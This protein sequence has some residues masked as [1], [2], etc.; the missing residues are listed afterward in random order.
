[1]D[2]DDEYDSELDDFIDDRPEGEIDY[3]QEIRNIFGY[4]KTKYRDFDDDDRNMESSFSRI[5]NEE[6]ISAK[7][8]M[9]YIMSQLIFLS[10]RKIKN[11]IL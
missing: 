11:K 3:S 2:D 10:N 4:D 8:G 1:M 5:M 7:F 9:Y 6:Y